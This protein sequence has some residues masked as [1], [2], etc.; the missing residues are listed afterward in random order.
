MRGTRVAPA[1]RSKEAAAIRTTPHG[2]VYPSMPPEGPARR[3]AREAT[4]RFLDVLPSP[5]TMHRQA[6]DAIRRVMSVDLRPGRRGV[7]M[8][9]EGIDRLVIHPNNRFKNA[10]DM[11]VACCIM[12]TSVSMPLKCARSASNPTC[13]RLHRTRLAGS[14]S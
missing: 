2:G 8:S 4:Q 11:L 12:F 1:A 9:P 6:A 13:A 3:L 5:C 14:H 7:D 10:F